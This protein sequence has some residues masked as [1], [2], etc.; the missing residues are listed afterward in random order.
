M[1]DIYLPRKLPFRSIYSRASVLVIAA[2]CDDAEILAAKGIVD[3]YH[4]KRAGLF[5]VICADNRGRPIHPELKKLTGLQIQK[6]REAEQKKAA[7]LGNYLG[8]DFLRLSSGDI[9]ASNSNKKKKSLIE[10]AVYEAIKDFS[11]QQIYTHSLFDK[12]PTHRVLA[13]R[14]IS[15]VRKLPAKKRPNGFYAAEVWGSLEWLPAQYR[16][17]FD[18]TSGLRLIKKLLQVYKSQNFK[19]HEYDKGFIGRLSSN[20]VFNNSHKDSEVKA[21]IYGL[22]LKPLLRKSSLDITK[23]MEKILEDYRKEKMKAIA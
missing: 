5:A 22:D 23:Y 17:D 15:A 20:A 3:A 19:N 21:L 1:S 13:Q 18:V 9:K 2:H 16:V 8:V 4:N 6:V 10:D 12:H 11:P 14:V 7:R